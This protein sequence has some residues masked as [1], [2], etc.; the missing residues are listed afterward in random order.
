MGR[1]TQQIKVEKITYAIICL[2]YILITIFQ[3]C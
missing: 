3:S 1:E 2:I